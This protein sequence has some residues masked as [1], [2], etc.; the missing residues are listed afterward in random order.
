MEG[1]R[2]GLGLRVQE[3]LPHAQCPGTQPSPLLALFYPDGSLGGIETLSN[4]DTVL[5]GHVT[6]QLSDAWK[7]TRYTPVLRPYAPCGAPF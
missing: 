3:R 4:Q 7:E 5:A 6:C 2:V 1:G